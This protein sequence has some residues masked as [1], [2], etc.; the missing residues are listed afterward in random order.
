MDAETENKVLKHLDVAR[1]VEINLAAFLRAKPEIVSVCYAIKHR[2]K[3]LDRISTKMTERNISEPG[4]LHDIC[5]F[6]LTTYFQSDIPGAVQSILDAIEKGGEGINPFLPDGPVSVVINT[7]RTEND[8]LA[9]SRET[10]DIVKRSK[11]QPTL[12]VRTRPTGYSSVHIVAWAMS[13]HE[14][15]VD[16]LAVE[17]QVRSVFEDI[18][19]EIDHRLRYGSQ[20]GNL[21]VSWGRHLNVFKALIDG[22]I[23]YVD[24]IKRD[25]N[26]SQP[27]A[28]NVARDTKPLATPASLLKVLEGLPTEIF[29]RV[30]K[31]YVL[32]GL[33]DK[34]RQNGKNPGLLREAAD[35]F[36]GILEDFSGEP[37]DNKALADDLIYSA[38]AE[39]AYLLMFTGDSVDLSEAAHIYEEIL[40]TRPQ[41]ATAL[42]RQGIVRRLQYRLDES[43]DLISQALAAIEQGTDQYINKQHWGYD[44][45]RL[46]LAMTRW[47]IYL[48]AKKNEKLRSAFDLAKSVL[49]SPADPSNRI[50]AVND[51]LY[52]A[53][54][55]TNNGLP[56]GQ[57]FLDDRNMFKYL[58]DLEKLLGEGK[59]GYEY[60][61]TIVRIYSR[62][63]KED[64]AK[65]YAAL[66]INILEVNAT[67]AGFG[68]A[69]AATRGTY[70]WVMA[71]SRYID[72][73]Q[74]DS[75]GFAQDVLT[76]ANRR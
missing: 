51:L 31:A 67:T 17:V 37:S 24:V 23:Q 41:D 50:R 54:E 43:E 52:Y 36:Q 74:L 63:G 11:L 68:T 60:Y 2:V 33:A 66:L 40:K 38:Q 9:I 45:A 48:S 46:N 26:E 19:G 15:K 25:A 32:W 14:E 6:R 35:E 39:R 65:K 75:L 73:E 13:K 5:G 61:D 34:E 47:R 58:K 57:A 42:F 64:E 70:A 44:M 76:S 72:K 4:G 53:W 8:P 55:S 16:Q 69:G 22:I 71:L 21:G 27:T 10:E 30:E 7:S 59:D 56:S 20:R 3:K 62:L 28:P 12:E 18:W 1:H 29:K 49:E